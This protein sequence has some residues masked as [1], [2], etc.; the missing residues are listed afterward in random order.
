MSVSQLRT[1]GLQ[2]ITRPA[3]PPVS[4]AMVRQNSDIDIDDH[5]EKLLMYLEAATQ[6]VQEQ[7]ETSLIKTKWRLTLDQFPRGNRWLILPRWPVSSIELIRYRDND[8]NWQTIDLSGIVLRKQKG[9]RSRIAR[10]DW[11]AWPSTRLTPDAV[12]IEFFA[13]A[14]TVAEV[15]PQFQQAILLLTSHW[16]EHP[17]ATFEGTIN[18][19]PMGVEALVMTMRD[20]DDAEDFTLE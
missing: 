5:D 1:Y 13:G 19:I 14:E 7:T 17:E 10:A 18:Q 16:F 15:D 9:G 11:D 3:C 4:L 12:E 20:P 2:V 6:W 8:N